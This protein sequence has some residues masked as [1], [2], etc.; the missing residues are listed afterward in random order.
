M[1]AGDIGLTE[2]DG[3]AVHADVWVY[4]LMRVMPMGWNWA[5]AW[6]QRVLQSRAEAA[7]L[8]AADRVEDGRVGGPV[9]RGR[10]VT[11]VDNFAAL[12]TARKPAD[13]VVTRMVEA[14][15]VAG[16]AVTSEESS[17]EL[18]KLLG[19]HFEGS[20]GV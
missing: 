5:L 1:R 2:L 8:P 9:G 10:H 15:E 16:L 18:V 19:W 7:G 17:C 13:D 4:P 6:C 14:L 12:A 11:Y 20:L 3:N